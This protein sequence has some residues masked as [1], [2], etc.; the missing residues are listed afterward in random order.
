MSRSVITEARFPKRPILKFG[1]LEI[2]ASGWRLGHWLNRCEVRI[3]FRELAKGGVHVETDFEMMARF[4]GIAE[5]RF[6]ATHVV[7]I[8]R[9]FAKNGRPGEQEFARRGRFAELVQTKSAMQET[10]AAFGRDAAK[11]SADPIER[12]AQLLRCMR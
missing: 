6:V 8:D 3:F 11:F 12:C 7:V 2:A 4:V 10:G 1:D 9:F 5:Q